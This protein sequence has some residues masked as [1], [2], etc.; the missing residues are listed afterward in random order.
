M[1]NTWLILCRAEL[2]GEAIVCS[3]TDVEENCLPV[4]DSV[5]FLLSDPVPQVCRERFYFPFT[6]RLRSSRDFIAFLFHAKFMYLP[7]GPLGFVSV[8]NLSSL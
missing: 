2:F 6:F 8:S 4:A 1:R 3:D 5:D 7:Q